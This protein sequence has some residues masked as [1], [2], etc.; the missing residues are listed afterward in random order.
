[1]ELKGFS[2][3]RSLHEVIWEVR[4]PSQERSEPAPAQ[5]DAPPLEDTSAGT[6]E[7]AARP[8]YDSDERRI[9]AAPVAMVGRDAELARLRQVL[10]EDLP[11]FN[12]LLSKKKVPG[13]F[14]EP[15]KESKKAAADKED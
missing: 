8:E 1:M 5:Q 3:A 15:K 10:S 13:V 7:V 11:K 12:E 9:L 4:S 2:G 14:I 6:V